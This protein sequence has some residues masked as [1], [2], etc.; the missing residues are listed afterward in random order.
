M[1]F[2][3]PDQSSTNNC[4]IS[5]TINTFFGR[6]FFCVVLLACSSVPCRVYIFAFALCIPFVQ[7]ILKHTFQ[8]MLNTQ[9][10]NESQ[11]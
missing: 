9:N 11:N 5:D 4:H 10:I 7:D 2:H 6:L 8:R 3:A 1:L